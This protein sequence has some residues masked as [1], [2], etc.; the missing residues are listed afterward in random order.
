MAK[1]ERI[2]C[3][4]GNCFLVQEN[5]HAVLID[6]SR[7]QFRDKILNVCKNKNVNL[8]VLTHGHVDHVQNAAYL[9]RELNV[10][11]AMHEADEELIKNNLLEPLFAHNIFGKLILALSIK[12]F[13][14][15][16]IESFKPK[17]FLHEG[18]SLENYGIHATVM[19]LPGH[20]KGSIGL[21]IGEKDIIV[22][23]A[24]MNMFYPS[25]S[26]L[27]GNRKAMEES[28]KKISGIHDVSIHFGHGK[29]VRN[30]NWLRYGTWIE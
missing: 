8:I 7:T 28:A 13:Q 12:S 4:N 23:D 3:G 6:T 14:D 30:R 11:I 9:S 29:S 5:N 24:L 10:P 20:T 19:E 15:D 2:K 22:G 21:K 25:R 18:D 1:I 26:M 17:V 27:Y 16:K